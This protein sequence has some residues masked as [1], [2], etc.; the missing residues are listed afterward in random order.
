MPIYLFQNPKTEEVIEVIQH[1]N[2]SH[3]FVDSNGLEYKRIYTVPSSSID[4]KIDAFSSKDFAEKTRNK[5]GTIGDLLNAS[6]E[7]SEKRGGEK[8]DP[9]LKNF[10]S[11]YKKEKG[12]KHSSEIKKEKLEKANKKLKKFGVSISD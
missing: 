2:E 3:T 5:K 11:S 7:L 8:N 12:V 4:S 10:L 6:K 1:M 9:V